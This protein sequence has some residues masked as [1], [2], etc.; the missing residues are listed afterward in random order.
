MALTLT[1][2]ALALVLTLETMG[3]AAN[4]FALALAQTATTITKPRRLRQGRLVAPGP[5]SR[6]VRARPSGFALS[7]WNT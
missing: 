6:N 7:V 2:F 5:G 3:V 1:A 4:P